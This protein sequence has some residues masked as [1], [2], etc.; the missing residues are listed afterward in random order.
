MV[1]VGMLLVCIISISLFYRL[2]LKNWF[3]VIVVVIVGG[4]S[5]WN[6]CIEM[7]LVRF[8]QYTKSECDEFRLVVCVVCVCPYLL[9]SHCF[10]HRIVLRKRE[11]LQPKTGLSVVCVFISFVEENNWFGLWHGMA[12]DTTALRHCTETETLIWLI[13]CVCFCV[14]LCCACAAIEYLPKLNWSNRMSSSG[15]VGY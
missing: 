15:F 3:F 4:I 9:F 1:M 13:G 2:K 12:R 14:C 8:A 11:T 5:K 7:G 6:K 10:H